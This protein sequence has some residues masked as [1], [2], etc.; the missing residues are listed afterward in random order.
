MPRL[1]RRRPLRERVIAWLNPMDTLLWLSEEIQ[2]RELDSQAVG[3]RVGVATNFI[4]FLTS[5][6]TAS[7]AGGDDIFSESSGPDWLLYLVS[8][9]AYSGKM[10]SID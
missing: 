8:C 10:L 5:A 2:T 7:S 1:V 6:N 3:T 4:Y 9:P